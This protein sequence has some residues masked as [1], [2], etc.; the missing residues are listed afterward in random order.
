M[1]KSIRTKGFT[2]VE[3]LV[4]IAIISILAAVVLY[5]S[6]KYINKG[7]DA[8]VNGNLAIL[9]TAGE[10]WYDKNSSTYTGFCGSDIVVKTLSQVPS[11]PADKYCNNTGTAWAV[12]AKEFVDKTK[13]YCVD[14][15]ANQTEID[16]VNCRNT[17][18]NC[19]FGAS[20][21]IP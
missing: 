17:I 21:C 12:C 8:S 19:C 16:F 14:N 11:A 2:L 1:K 6:T 20:N 15:K 10:V 18:T 5:S 7:K 3:M 9:I 4:V 13:A